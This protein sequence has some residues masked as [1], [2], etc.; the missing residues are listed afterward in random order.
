MPMKTILQ[1]TH[2]LDAAGVD[3]ISEQIAD[4]LADY[5]YITKRDI[6]RLRLSAEEI[7][8]HWRQE[9]GALRVQLS[10]EEKG[11]W[12]GLMSGATGGGRDL[13]HQRRGGY[14]GEFGHRLDLPV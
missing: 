10:I 6:L 8:L 3:N 9:A 11:R 13:R 12:I 7:L 2:P 4:V 5:P 1:D 14:A